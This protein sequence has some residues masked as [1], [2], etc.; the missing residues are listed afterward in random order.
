MT[1]EKTAFVGFSQKQHGKRKNLVVAFV[2]KACI[3]HTEIDKDL[4]IGAVCA[5]ERRDYYVEEIYSVCKHKRK[6]GYGIR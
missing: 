4:T 5:V 2:G 1:K 6:I 3:M